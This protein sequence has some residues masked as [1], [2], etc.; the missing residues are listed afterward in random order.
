M[1]KLLVLTAIA[2]AGLMLVAST[3]Y[4]NTTIDDGATLGV[5]VMVTLPVAEIPLDA[6]ASFTLYSDGDLSGSAMMLTEDTPL[7]GAE[8]V[9]GFITK[10]D[11]YKTMSVTIAGT[12]FMNYDGRA[13]ALRT[14]LKMHIYGWHWASRIAGI[15]E[16]D[17]LL[18]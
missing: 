16:G 18:V 10:P 11:F 17:G 2:I 9:T 5:T 15:G 12:D 1:R 7:I 6:A 13:G 3:S 8:K 4:T 14:T